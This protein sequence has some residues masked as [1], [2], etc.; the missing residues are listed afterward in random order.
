MSLLCK[1]RRYTCKLIC[2]G[3]RLLLWPSLVPPARLDDHPICQFGRSGSGHIWL[4]LRAPPFLLFQS[5]VGGA[6]HRCLN[7]TWCAPSG[8]VS[9]GPESHARVGKLLWLRG[10]RA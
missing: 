10:S 6:P 1:R 5:A 2:Q 3:Q 8:G 4:S 7:Q 9:R